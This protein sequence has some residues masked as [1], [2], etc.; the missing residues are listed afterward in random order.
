MHVLGLPLAFILSQDQTLHCKFDIS[1]LFLF[2]ALKDSSLE[3]IRFFFVLLYSYL[4]DFAWIIRSKN[5]AKTLSFP[6]HRSPCFASAK[7]LLFPF[8]QTLSITFF[9][10]NSLFPLRA[11]E[12]YVTRAKNMKKGD[13]TT[14]FRL[15]NA[16]FRTMTGRKTPENITNRALSRK[17]RTAMVPLRKQ[18]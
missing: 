10:K 17:N 12:Q 13:G 2:C 3:L 16:L 9:Q 18:K 11:E 15:K 14:D 7:I 6:Q 4:S 5:F 8:R 1:S